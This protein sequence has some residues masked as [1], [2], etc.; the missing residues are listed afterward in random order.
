MEISKK[1]Y[2]ILCNK[3]RKNTITDEGEIWRPSVSEGA[4]H[5]VGNRLTSRV[6]YTIFHA[7]GN[8]T[9]NFQGSSMET[10]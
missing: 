9:S 1:V 7:T 2:S 4:H 8:E 10:E 3:G 5:L 6:S